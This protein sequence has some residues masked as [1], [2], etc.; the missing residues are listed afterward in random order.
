M[1]Q[2]RLLRTELIAIFTGLNDLRNRNFGHGM[3]VNFGLTAAEVNF[4]HL[5]SIAAILLLTQTR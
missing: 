2:N 5:S 4:T 3:A 1:D